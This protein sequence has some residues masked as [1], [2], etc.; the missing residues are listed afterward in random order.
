L[1]IEYVRVTIEQLRLIME[2][3]IQEATLM[4]EATKTAGQLTSTISAGALAAMHV[5]A[6]AQGSGSVSAS[7]SQSHGY[8]AQ[9]STNVSCGTSQSTNISYEADTL[10][11]Y[12]CGLVEGVDGNT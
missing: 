12:F 1:E 3:A 8:S 5:G 4:L 9:D 7:G 11:G 6:T 2:K 10:P